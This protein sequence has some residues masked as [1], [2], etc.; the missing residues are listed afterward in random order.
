MFISFP[1]K[2]VTMFPKA[3]PGR[4]KNS[5]HIIFAVISIICAPA[6][7]T[8]RAT[9][10][11]KMIIVI[12]GQFTVSYVALK[13]TLCKCNCDRNAIQWCFFLSCSLILIDIIITFLSFICYNSWI[14]PLSFCIIRTKYKS[15]IWN[16]TWKKW[17]RNALKN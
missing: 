3:I 8:L 9:F 5:E 6:P 11:T 7:D 10:Y 15:K 17:E 12:Q 14:N 1:Y 16:K 4:I 13:Q 2:Q